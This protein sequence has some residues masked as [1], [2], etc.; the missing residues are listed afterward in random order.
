MDSETSLDGL[1][2]ETEEINIPFARTLK[3]AIGGIDILTL[4]NQ[5]ATLTAE[6]DAWYSAFGTTQLTHAT[7][8]LRVAEFERDALVAQLETA[9]RERDSFQRVG[10]HYESVLFKAAN[11]LNPDGSGR[12]A[13][14]V[15]LSDLPKVMAERDAL[16]SAT[17]RLV[18]A[19]RNA[20][21]SISDS[22]NLHAPDMCGKD[23]MRATLKR[24]YDRGGTLAYLAD[25][26][27]KIK[28]AL[29]DPTIV[30]LRRE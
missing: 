12:T 6:R 28:S 26:R 17:R 11:M 16:Q 24:C 3:A 5:I 14:L 4:Q 8:R 23:A 2:I 21:K 25:A 30:E 10:K 22:M 27:R 1:N 7:E 18:E 15:V 13:A 20:S 19:A 9:K 29:A